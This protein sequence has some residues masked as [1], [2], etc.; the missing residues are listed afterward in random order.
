MFSSFT[1]FLAWLLLPAWPGQV[2]ADGEPY[3]CGAEILVRV[4]L[5]DEHRWVVVPVVVEV[6]LAVP[7]TPQGDS[8]RKVHEGSRWQGSPLT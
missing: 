8:R 1:S 7:M 6:A 3:A 4:A 2:V 5:T